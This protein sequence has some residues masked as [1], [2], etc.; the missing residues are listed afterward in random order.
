MSHEDLVQFYNEA[1]LIIDQFGG[2][3]AFGNVT[4]EALACEKTVITDYDGA[5]YPEKPPIESIEVNE[6]ANTI[7]KLVEKSKFRNPNGRKW[8]LKYHSFERAKEIMRK[9]LKRVG[10]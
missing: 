4:I 10:L 3:R 2:L 7:L 1:D 9:E 5:D 8:V 6:L